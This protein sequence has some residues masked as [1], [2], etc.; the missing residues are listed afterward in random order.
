MRAMVKGLS[1]RATS[2]SASFVQD[3]FGLNLKSRSPVFV[4]YTEIQN[5]VVITNKVF[6][7]VFSVGEFALFTFFF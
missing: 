7:C 3:T 2:R 5:F 4:W 6:F 1:G